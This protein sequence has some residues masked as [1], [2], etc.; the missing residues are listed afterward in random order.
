MILIVILLVLI[1]GLLLWLYVQVQGRKLGSLFKPSISVDREENPGITLVGK[2]V[3]LVG[4]PDYLIREKGA[5]IPV[6]VK[7]GKTPRTPH[8]N[9]TMQLMAYCLLIEEVYGQL[10]PGGYLRYPEKEFKIAYTEEARKSVLDLISEITE[11]K[12]KN[13]EFTCKHPYH[14]TT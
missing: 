8:T 2:S 13:Q 5:I 9:H 6:E 10:P 12:R 1:G 11:C 7:T 14:N 3:P 4:R